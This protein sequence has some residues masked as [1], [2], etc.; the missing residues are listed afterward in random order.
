MDAAAL[1]ATLTKLGE[2]MPLMADQVGEGIETGNNALEAARTMIADGRALI[3]SADAAVEA[4]ENVV[5]EFTAFAN[6]QRIAIDEAYEDV[7]AKIEAYTDLD[8]VMEAVDAGVGEV[9][10]AFESFQSKLDAG[11]QAGN[12]AADAFADKLEAL[13]GA[14]DEGTQ[15]LNNALDTATSAFES[16]QEGLNTGRDAVLSEVDSF[17]GDLTGRQE[18]FASNVTQY[19]SN[20]RQWMGDLGQQLSQG[21]PSMI[22]A[23]V[24]KALDDV[25]AKIQEQIQTLVREAMDKVCGAL[26]GFADKLTE[27]NEGSQLGRQILEPIFDQFSSLADPLVGALDSV[28]SAA[29][30]VGIDL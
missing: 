25:Q 18:E 8:P 23:E 24:T 4:A 15:E 28:K 14:I 21:F 27:A 7:E 6:E 17:V 3:E 1:K 13:F 19:V 29:S 2:T 16:L 12:A 11:A 30:T 20:G 26:D 22:E 10:G 5:R 9:E